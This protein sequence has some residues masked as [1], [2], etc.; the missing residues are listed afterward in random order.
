MRETLRDELARRRYEFAAKR[1][2]WRQT[3][4][5]LGDDGRRWWYHDMRGEN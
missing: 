2:G 4:T 1:N 3:W 5:E